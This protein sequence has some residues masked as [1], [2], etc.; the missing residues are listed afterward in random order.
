[1]DESKAATVG[2]DIEKSETGRKNGQKCFDFHRIR[3][4]IAVIFAIFSRCRSQ[5]KPSRLP[6]APDLHG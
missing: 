4:V 6:K 1:M 5:N 2:G 3:I